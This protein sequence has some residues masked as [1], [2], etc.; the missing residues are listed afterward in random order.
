M[1]KEGG[2]GWCQQESPLLAATTT[3]VVV[4]GSCGNGG[5]SVLGLLRSYDSR[6]YLLNK[7][8]EGQIWNLKKLVLG[9]NEIKMDCI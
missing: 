5:P 1:L 8:C 3:A 6:L 2:N 9:C 7:F 4:G